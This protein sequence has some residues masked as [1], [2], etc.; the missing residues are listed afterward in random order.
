ANTVYVDPDPPMATFMTNN[1]TGAL[2]PPACRFRSISNPNVSGAI[3][4]VMAAGN[5]A[6]TRIV[7]IH[8]TSSNVHFKMEIPP[9]VIPAGIEVTT[10][11]GPSFNPSH[12]TLDLTGTGTT[13]RVT[14]ANGSSLSGFTL[15][16]T[17]LTGP[18]AA[19]PLLGFGSG[20][21]TLNLAAS[22]HHLALVGA[23]A[24]T[25]IS[26][27]A[28]GTLTSDLVTI[29][30][31]ATAINVDYPGAGT[32][33]A[34]FTGTSITGTA[35]GATGVAVADASSRVTLSASRFDVSGNQG[36]QVLGGQATLNA[37]ILNVSGAGGFGIQ[38]NAGTTTVTGTSPVTV[39]GAGSTGLQL[40]GAGAVATLTGTTFSLTNVTAAS[41]GIDVLTATPML[42]MTGGSVTLTNAAAAGA[43]GVDVQNA[44]TVALSGT[45]VTTGAMANGVR[46]RDTAMVTI[47]GASV[48]TNSCAVTTPVTVG[49]DTINGVVGSTTGSG[50]IIPAGVANAGVVVNVAGTTQVTKYQ[51]GIEVNDGSLAVTGTVQINGNTDDGVRSWGL[52]NTTTT[53]VSI[54][55]ATINGNGDQGVSVNTS[56]PTTVQMSTINSNKGDGIAVQGSQATDQAGFRFLASTNTVRLNGGRGVYVSGDASRSGVRIEGN[57]IAANVLEGIRISELSADALNLTEASITGNT[58]NG[59]LT[60]AATAPAHILAGG[61]FFT[62][63]T[64]LGAAAS[65]P[66]RITLASFLG[67]RVFAN[68]RHEI[69]FDVAQLAGAWDISS[70]SSAVDMALVCSDSARPNSVYCYDT[71]PGEDLGVAIPASSGILIKAKGV[72]FQNAL[73]LAGRDYSTGIA[74]P[75]TL[76]PEPTDGV[77]LSCVAAT[78]ACAP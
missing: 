42:T 40:L 64:T 76:T 41:R 34:G 1:P 63:M 22:A 5:G 45:T 43:V 13:P 47:N 66:V 56:V 77:F 62:G 58:V 39:S 29:S 16:G 35:I 28:N 30:A 24:G 72:H 73:P 71:V 12:Y 20:H 3:P 57:T 8:E 78:G 38:N 50:I 46:A 15:D 21:A 6:F 49:C 55:G 11:D 19:A 25:G 4:F 61:V 59:N 7:A 27:T 14:I 70:N 48:V 51:R 32:A 53:T 74:A 52:A 33:P 17:A 2:Q 36:I 60:S 68:G 37:V 69:G 67:N 10:A 9:L 75:T 65:A 23:G 54:T 31:V 26:V 18:A 44:S